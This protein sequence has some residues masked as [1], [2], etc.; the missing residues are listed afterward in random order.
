M[1]RHSQYLRMKIKGKHSVVYNKVTGQVTRIN[2]G[3]N[4]TRTHAK[5]WLCPK[6]SYK[7]NQSSRNCHDKG[8]KQ[9]RT[10]TK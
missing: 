10:I 4:Q 6:C 9:K 3:K 7:N 1:G 5:S 8:C 2:K